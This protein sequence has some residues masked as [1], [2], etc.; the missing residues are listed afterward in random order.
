MYVAMFDE[1]D[2]GTAILKAADSYFA[3]PTNQYFLTTSADGTYISSDFYLRLVGKATRVFKGLDPLTSQVTIPY[4]VGPDWF[5]TSVEV[6][7]DALI[8]KPNVVESVSNVLGTGGSGSPVCTVTS[9]EISHSGIYSIKFS[10]N[11]NSSTD[12]YCSFMAFDV[13]IPVTS[14]LQLSYW[15]YPLNE[16]GRYAAVDL[17]ITDGSRLRNLD[18]KDV[19][20]LSMKPSQGR[21]AVNTWNKS[22]C[23]IGQWLNGKTIDKILITYDQPASI[24]NFSGY[25]DDII[26]TT[27]SFSTGIEN[28]S[29]DNQ[30]AVRIYPTVLHNEDM[31][32][33]ASALN[34]NSQKLNLYVTTIEGEVMFNR[35]FMNDTKI[36]ISLQSLSKGIYLVEVKGDNFLIT[37]KVI[38]Y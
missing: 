32:V 25:V 23:N 7:S 14:D 20:G 38:K 28:I 4:S 27:N 13:D 9:G 29:T 19:N 24:G 10:G 31:I 12:S 11:D 6:G 21:G 16:N 1:Y 2:E 37:Q 15:S 30:T 33:D 17:L 18:L 5:R 8:L 3:K 35:S 36:I 34:I 26:L 22:V